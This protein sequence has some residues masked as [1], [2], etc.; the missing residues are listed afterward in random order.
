MFKLIRNFFKK[1]KELKGIVV[2]IDT[3][4][5]WDYVNTETLVKLRKANK[6]SFK[7]GHK[8]WNKGK[9]KGK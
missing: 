8:P 9:K 5:V 1:K 2:R 3:P 7:K 4:L 6:T